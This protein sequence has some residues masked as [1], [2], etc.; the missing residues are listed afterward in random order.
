MSLSPSPDALIRLT[1]LSIIASLAAPG[2]TATGL[3]CGAA[4]VDLPQGFVHNGTAWTLHCA[5]IASGRVYAAFRSAGPAS[6]DDGRAAALS[7][8]GHLA[9]IANEEEN[10]LVYSVLQGVN[11][12]DIGFT[13]RDSEG[14]W[15]WV[16]GEPTT[17]IKWA[18]GEPNDSYPPL[19]EDGAEMYGSTEP[20]AHQRSR[21]ND[22]VLS[23]KGARTI[24]VE[25]GLA[26][27]QAPLQPPPAAC[28]PPC[29]WSDGFEAYP[30]GNT[31]SSGGWQRGLGGQAV[32][33]SDRVF[34]GNRSYRMTAYPYW[35]LS[36][37][38]AA[39]TAP[40]VYIET[41]A[42]VNFGAAFGTGT[43]T[44]GFKTNDGPASPWV[45]G[46][47]LRPNGSIT[48]AAQGMTSAVSAGSWAPN[49]WVKLRLGL[50]VPTAATP[51]R[52]TLWVDD[53]QPV[54]AQVPPTTTGSILRVAQVA[55]GAHAEPWVA[56]TTAWF[57]NVRASSISAG[58]A[59]PSPPGAPTSLTGPGSPLFDA[60]PVD[61]THAAVG[62]TG[63]HHERRT[64]DN[65]N[66]A[67][68]QGA[69]WA[70]TPA[71]TYGVYTY[72]YASGSYR[73][74][75]VNMPS[76]VG[77]VYAGYYPCPGGTGVM[78]WKDGQFLACQASPAGVP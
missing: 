5:T 36:A 1:L 20:Q 78:V 71:G 38:R 39:G 65:G 31:A 25:R 45:A 56:S 77:N 34:D 19:G 75:L 29:V 76:P 44:V 10:A 2:V 14:S 43:A 61:D 12:A 66:Y 21:W 51:G 68:A 6:W 40:L 48:F 15:R 53:G 70:T 42:M 18:P 59:I 64:Y 3:P 27:P 52:I 22:L 4:P 58:T 23:A 47:D 41:E 13:D 28:A 8:G 72:A 60:T 11:R 46:A 50:V 33:A 9:T 54:S 24:V 67:Y 49:E 37:H 17:F 57:D 62:S 26:A 35:A 63:V 69:M 55:L 30:V 32:V 16:T 74:G 7:I 73:Y